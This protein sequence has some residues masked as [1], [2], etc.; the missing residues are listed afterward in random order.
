MSRE[1]HPLMYDRERIA[2]MGVEQCQ[3]WMDLA[4]ITDRLPYDNPRQEEKRQI[5]SQ[6]LRAI[7]T[8]QRQ[9]AGILRERISHAEIRCDAAVQ[10]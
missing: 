5:A 8:R 4:A 1:R 3:Y 7:L 10:S 6:W 2:F 9:K